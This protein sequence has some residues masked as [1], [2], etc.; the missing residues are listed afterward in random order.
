MPT[1]FKRH[2]VDQFRKHIFVVPFY[3]DNIRELAELI[4][5]ERILFGSDFP[6]PEGLAQPLD[7]VS[8]F[9]VLP[10]SDVRKVMSEN[11]QGLLQGARN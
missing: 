1:Y 3:E 8:E 7:Y 2:P 9:A 6:H 4:P 5:V 11:L 10:K